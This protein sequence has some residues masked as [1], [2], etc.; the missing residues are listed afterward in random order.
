MSFDL[1][2]KI[3]IVGDSY[4]P[5]LLKYIDQESG[6]DVLGKIDRL[7]NL[8]R[9]DVY[10]EFKGKPGGE[11]NDLQKLA[12]QEIINNKTDVLVLMAGGNDIDGGKKE[13][14]AVARDI[15]DFAKTLV[16]ADLVKFVI[17]TQIIAR[18]NPKFSSADVY[19]NKARDTNKEL[20]TRTRGEEKLIYWSHGRLSYRSS[21]GPDGIHLSEV[22]NYLLYH[23]LKRAIAH[24]INHLAKDEGCGRRQVEKKRRRAGR[25]ERKR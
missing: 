12:L 5:R 1:Q 19:K 24:A 3:A 13:P 9:E 25:I 20:E 15:V 23:S 21:N 16:E 6:K 14:D 10:I 7:F 4:V 11:F 17:M 8:Y 18:K 2:V 22:G